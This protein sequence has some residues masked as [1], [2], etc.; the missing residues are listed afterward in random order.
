MLRLQRGLEN[1]CGGARTQHSAQ[2]AARLE[3][4]LPRCKAVEPFARVFEFVE[5]VQQS[6]L[7]D[8][9]PHPRQSVDPRWRQSL[10]L[11]PYNFDLRSIAGTIRDEPREISSR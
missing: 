7:T 9:G 8:K 11:P 5:I 3:Q 4:A 2:Q 6:G 1:R 10:L